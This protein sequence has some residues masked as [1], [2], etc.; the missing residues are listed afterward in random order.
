MIFL[1]FWYYIFM[2][3]TYL[4]YIYY[5]L[6]FLIFT[7][8]FFLFL[9]PNAFFMMMFISQEI[10]FNQFINFKYFINQTHQFYLSKFIIL[11]WIFE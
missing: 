1:L 10:L 5:Y 3:I 4:N 9:H 8:S 7:P 2:I 6:L 11:I